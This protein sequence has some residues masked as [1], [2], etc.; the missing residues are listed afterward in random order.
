MALS[1]NRQV[2]FFLITSTHTA[3]TD[4]TF[5]FD[6]SVQ[7]EIELS[8]LGHP[9]FVSQKWIYL[10][11]TLPQFHFLN[12]DCAAFDNFGPIF[13]LT[14]DLCFS[15]QRV[16]PRSGHFDLHSFEVPW[17]WPHRS[18]SPLDILNMIRSSWFYTILSRTACPTIHTF[19]SLPVKPPSLPCVSTIHG[20]CYFLIEYISTDLDSFLLPKIQLSPAHPWAMFTTRLQLWLSVL[21]HCLRLSL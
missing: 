4:F 18:C 5:N 2:C 16:H 3:I 20:L 6:V 15:T 10:L 12:N 7:A 21:M 9:A 19:A 14:H 11:S 17:S 8:S 1:P 13:L